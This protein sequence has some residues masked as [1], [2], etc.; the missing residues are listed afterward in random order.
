M[1]SFHFCVIIC[2]CWMLLLG[3]S[4]G[5]WWKFRFMSL[6]DGGFGWKLMFLV[7]S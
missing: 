2:R 7:E 1:E 5:F 6:L 3:E 4:C